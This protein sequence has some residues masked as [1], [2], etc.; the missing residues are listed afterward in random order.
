MNSRSA[1]RAVEKIVWVVCVAWLVCL[2]LQSRAQDAGQSAAGRRPQAKTEQE[3][4]DFNRAYAL[5]GGGAC[6]AAANDFAGKYPES[7]LRRYLYSNAMLQYQRENNPE[8]MLAMGERV[9]AL[10]PDNPLAL[11]LTATALADSLGDRDRD[12][13]RKIGSIKRNAARAIQSAEIQ[14]ASVNEDAALYKTTLQSMAYSALG[15]MKLKT[16]D[17][18][19]AERDLKA[20]ADL[21]KAQPDPYVWYHLALAQD[22]R[23]KYTAAL[24]SVDQA[25]QLSSSN[26]DLQKL[27]EAEHERLAGLAKG[28]RNAAPA[29]PQ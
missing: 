18:A 22:H 6:A 3:R 14:Y 27:A 10:D 8:K 19:G 12:R 21:K 24:N 11:V 25:L 13:E 9:L 2:P 16:G 4:N 7:E 26:P 20:A 5:T 1:S 23:K 15:I 17:D 28:P 29:E